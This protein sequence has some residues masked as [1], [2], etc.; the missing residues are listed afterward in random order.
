RR[1]IQT[2]NDA[3]AGKGA[4]A[5]TGFRFTLKGITRT[6]NGAWYRDPERYERTFKPKLRKGG[7]GTLNLYS[8]D[9]GEEML[10]WSTFPWKYKADPKMDGVIIHPESMPHGSIE[11]FNL[12]HT[13]THEI[14]HWL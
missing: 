9:M 11:N 10:G 1:Q 7:A 8:A 2:L 5:D 13:A 3:H 4:G 14:G 12:G 6:N